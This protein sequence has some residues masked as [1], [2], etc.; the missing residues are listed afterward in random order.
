MPDSD[1]SKRDQTVAGAFCA[2][3]LLGTVF[4]AYNIGSSQGTHQGAQQEAARQYSQNAY[5]DALRACAG[6][7]EAAAIECIRE[8]VISSEEQSNSRQ[9]L[10]AQQDMADW[11]F[12]MLIA[13]CF[14]LGVTALGVWFVKRTLD[15]TL[16]AVEDTGRA[17]EE[18]RKANAIA[19]KMGEIQVR[20]YLSIEKVEIGFNQSGNLLLHVQV[21]NSGNSPAKLVRFVGDIE[22]RG[23]DGTMGGKGAKKFGVQSFPPFPEVPA[24]SVKDIGEILT[25]ICLPEFSELG[26]TGPFDEQYTYPSK[27]IFQ[28][29]GGFSL[30][31]KDVF[32]K[33]VT[34]P[35]EA[36]IVVAPNYRPGQ[37][38]EMEQTSATLSRLMDMS[39]RTL[40]DHQNEQRSGE[41]ES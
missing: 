38:F 13:T 9:D 31:A 37:T 5:Q 11:A 21:R 26:L 39:I 19:Q 27:T 2:I 7:E 18:M 29:Q 41:P 36:Y 24:N 33:S 12:W 25:P 28:F 40:K 8:A 17:T 14:T 22:P 15:A 4:L 32:G 34:S 30:I 10:Q 20:A 3:A 1:R 16:Q 23:P 35:N 6:G